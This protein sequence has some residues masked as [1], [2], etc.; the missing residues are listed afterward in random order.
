L[1]QHVGQQQCVERGFGRRLE[2]HRAARQERRYQFGDDEEL[3]HVPRHDGGHHANGL[4]LHEHIG[5]EEAV[6][7]LLPW[8]VLGEVAE[9]AHHHCG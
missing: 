2:H 1:L 9:R 6:P 4:F 5:A 8:V 7:R 3:G